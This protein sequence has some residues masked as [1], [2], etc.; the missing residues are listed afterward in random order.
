M[1]GHGGYVA[2]V[3]MTVFGEA[4]WAGLRISRD[5]ERGKGFEEW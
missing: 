5:E 4:E 1:I 2:Y 3:D